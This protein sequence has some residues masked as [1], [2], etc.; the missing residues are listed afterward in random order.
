MARKILVVRVPINESPMIDP[1]WFDGLQEDYH[2]FLIGQ[3]NIDEMKFEFP[4]N[5]EL[6]QDDLDKIKEAI[7][8]KG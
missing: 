7:L 8:I 5:C 1:K 4:L 6:P 3:E 2:V